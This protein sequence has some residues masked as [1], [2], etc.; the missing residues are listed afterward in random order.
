MM[1]LGHFKLSVADRP[2]EYGRDIKQIDKLTSKVIV[3]WEMDIK[4]YYENR[5]KKD[6]HCVILNVTKL[7]SEEDKDISNCKYRITRGIN[8]EIVYESQFRSDAEDVYKSMVEL[9]GEYMKFELIAVI[10]THQ[11]PEMLN[12]N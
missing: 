1:Y 6:V 2:Y 11:P 10:E 5:T 8:K 7:D 4:K 9:D 3:D 12:L